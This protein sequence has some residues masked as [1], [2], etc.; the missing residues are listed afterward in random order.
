MSI[1]IYEASEFDRQ[2]LSEHLPGEHLKFSPDPLT[3][4]SQLITL[5]GPDGLAEIE[6]ISVFVH[7]R[8]DA[9]IIEA[10]PNLKLVTTRSTGFDHI[11]V[12]ACESRGIPVSTVPTYGEN[13]VA[14]H[15]FALI[16]ALSRNVHKAY[17]RTSSGDFSLE[18]LQGFD[19]KGKTIGIVGVGHIGLHTIRIAKGFGMDVLAYDPNPNPTAAE[20]IG[21][22]YTTL[23][24]LL[25]RSDIVSLHAPYNTATHH[26]IGEE[27]IHKI[28]R[29]AL[30]I[31]TARGALVDTGALLRA[32][33]EGILRGAGLDVVEGEEVFS[34]EKQL[35]GNAD[36]SSDRLRMALR[37]LSLLKRADLIV[38]PHIAFDSAEAMERILATTTENILAWRAGSPKNVVHT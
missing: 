33:D 35:I 10:L 4:V 1:Y 27:N 6:S 19:L 8:V 3:D 9:E 28:K 12:P 15:T 30:L 16:L 29:G 25:G 13:T 24:D 34:E 11:N 5:A 36:A 32:L 31:N 17:N 21:Y 26:L 38:T 7:S 2:Y 37:N 23:D 20:V 14:E 18:G 22:K